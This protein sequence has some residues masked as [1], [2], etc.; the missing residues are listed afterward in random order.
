M[1]RRLEELIAI[2]KES[3]T[4]ELANE[5]ISFMLENIGATDPRLETSSYT[6]H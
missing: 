6:E 4:R 1:K 5:M 3:M 2:S